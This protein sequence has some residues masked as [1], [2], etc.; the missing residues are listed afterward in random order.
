MRST[1]K[2]LQWPIVLILSTIAVGL[3]TFVFP[4]II[5][6]PFVVFWFLFICPGM[7]LVR[8]LHLKEPLIEWVLALALSFSIDAIVAGVQLYAGRWA[9]TGTLVILMSLCIAG[10]IMQIAMRLSPVNGQ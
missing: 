10:A 7:V 8:F 2:T 3:V 9:P 1:W 4:T 6:R 5:V